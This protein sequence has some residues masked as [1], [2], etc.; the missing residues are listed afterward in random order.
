M[1]LEQAGRWCVGERAPRVNWD[2]YTEPGRPG[3]RL[4]ITQRA[5]EGQEALE[6]F[7]ARARSA[8]TEIGFAPSTHA[9]GVGHAPLEQSHAWGDSFPNC[10]SG[11][12]RL[13][14]HPSAHRQPWRPSRDFVAV[15]I[16]VLRLLL[17]SLGRRQP[18]E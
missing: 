15:P 18:S 9:A 2:P 3:H 7:P 17:L 4:P 16:R 6:C 14:P 1:G 8:V 12:K 13:D 5:G 10:G 11:G